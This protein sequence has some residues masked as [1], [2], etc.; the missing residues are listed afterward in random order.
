LG[1][2]CWLQFSDLHLNPRVNFDTDLARAKLLEHLK[3]QNLKIDYIFITGDIADKSNYNGAAEFITELMDCA[4]VSRKNVYWSVGNHD[5]DRGFKERELFIKSI[6]EAKDPSEEYQDIMSN[7]AYREVMTE[8][9]M[10]K[11][12]A[13]YRKLFKRRLSARQTSDAHVLYP[14]KRVN[15][16][17][18]NTC[19][20]S[21][22]GH[23]TKK[24]MIAEKRIL[25]VFRR[26]HQKKPLFVIGHHGKS[27]FHEDQQK[28]IETLFSS[29]GVDIYLCGHSHKL[30]YELLADG[31][32]QKKT[33]Q[34]TC[35][36]GIIDG[37][38]S[39]SFF[40]G[41][42][43]TQNCAVRLTSH[44]YSEKNGEFTQRKMLVN[45]KESL[46]IRG[47]EP[48]AIDLWPGF[49]M[50]LFSL[51][52]LIPQCLRGIALLS[53]SFF[54]TVLGVLCALGYIFWAHRK[55]LQP[56]KGRIDDPRDDG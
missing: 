2:F 26:C 31:E 25:R 32:E 15:L 38:S 56:S 12:V 24:L 29:Y 40:H 3:N 37:Y 28:Y 53:Y 49:I 39:F 27:F 13:M 1:S 18:L 50:L 19:L 36:G 52:S 4:K 34:I 33:H 7:E 48:S 41:E 11:Y 6:R 10:A 42:Y 16:V 17:V 35:G 22:D 14:L 44:N 45:G 23:D 55:N 9:A 51:M 20:T 30:G 43:D 47:Y 21:C 5:I 54:V 8:K 46:K